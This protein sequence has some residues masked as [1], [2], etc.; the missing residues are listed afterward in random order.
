MTRDADGGKLYFL[1][2]LL[3][4]GETSDPF[5]VISLQLFNVQYFGA[6][7]QPHNVCRTADSYIT[8]RT[9]EDG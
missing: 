9:S 1:A 5:K 8:E 3:V 2:T 6:A 4:T 7:W